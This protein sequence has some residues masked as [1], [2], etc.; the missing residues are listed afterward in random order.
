MFIY[1]EMRPP[2]A[3]FDGESPLRNKSSK[4]AFDFVNGMYEDK[5]GLRVSKE[6]LVANQTDDG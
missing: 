1:K 2:V 4:T 3:S 6:Q 5:L